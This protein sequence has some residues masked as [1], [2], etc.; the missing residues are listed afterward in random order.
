[1]KSALFIFLFFLFSLDGFA[2][3]KKFIWG[4]WHNTYMQPY[5]TFKEK[6]DRPLIEKHLDHF[7]KIG[8]NRI[9]FLV[10][11]PTG[12]VFYKSK[13]APIHPQLDWDPFDFLV[14][15]CKKRKIEIYPYINVL[16]EGEYNEKTKK[17]DNIGPYL[18]KFPGHAMQNKEGEKY[19]WVSPAVEEAIN[20]ELSLMEEI[21]TNYAVDGVQLDR[22]RYPDSLADYNPQSVSLYQKLYQKEPEA[23][24]YSWTLYRQNLLTE[25]VAK[26]KKLL[27]SINPELKLSAATFP[28]PYSAAINQLQAWPRWCR[29]GLLDEVVPMTYYRNLDLFQTYLLQNQEVTPAN[30]PLLPGI[31]AF[32]IQDPNILEGQIQLAL[33]QGVQGIVFFSGYFLL[34]ENLANVVKKY[35]VEKGN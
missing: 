2:K 12:H 26:A 14:K 27:N 15:E 11:F 17:E 16:A 32:F 3:E 30:I 33:K 19:G 28:R 8:I 4:I 18:E 7:Q 13:I 23:G 9:Y 5:I 24:D 20:Y 22:I 1:M 25:V 31:G 10:K 29:Q 35:A 21:I 34:E 6:D